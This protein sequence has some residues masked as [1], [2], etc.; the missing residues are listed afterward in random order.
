MPAKQEKKRGLK[1]FKTIKVKGHPGLFIHVAIVKK[2]GPKGGHT[3]AG[4]VH[5]KKSSK[6]HR[7]F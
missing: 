5:K 4:K 3:I 6:K 7:L 1:G 2:A